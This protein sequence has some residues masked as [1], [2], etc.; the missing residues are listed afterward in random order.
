MTTEVNSPPLRFL[1][2]L[3]TPVL[4]VAGGFIMAADSSATKEGGEEEI[5]DGQSLDFESLI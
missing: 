4:S 1:R 3:Q 2:Y 5:V